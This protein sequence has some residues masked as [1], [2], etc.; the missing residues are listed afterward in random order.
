LK[1]HSKDLT[2]FI[3]DLSKLAKAQDPLKDSS[4]LISIYAKIYYIIN[5]KQLSDMLVT[6]IG[7]LKSSVLVAS[8][9]KPFLDLIYKEKRDTILL[10]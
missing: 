10:L 8:G 1:Q 4:E 6:S 2:V 7:Y 9:L 3:A 5:S